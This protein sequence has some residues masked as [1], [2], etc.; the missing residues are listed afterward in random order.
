MDEKRV[1]EEQK[2]PEGKPVP[3]GKKLED[4][5]LETAAGGAPWMTPWAEKKQLPNQ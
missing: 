3:A 5:E 4:Q 1:K 2:Q